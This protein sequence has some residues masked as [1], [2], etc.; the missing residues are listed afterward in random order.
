MKIGSLVICEEETGGFH[1]S[2]SVSSRNGN[3]EAMG[4]GQREER[5]VSSGAS[6][7]PGR[8]GW[9]GRRKPWAAGGEEGVG[10]GWVWEGRRIVREKPQSK[11]EVI[12]GCRGTGAA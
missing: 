10:E 4:W 6:P 9:K 3:W 7:H 8:E 12:L 1:C 11:R 5:M 2:A